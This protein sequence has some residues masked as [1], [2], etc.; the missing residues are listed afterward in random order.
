[1]YDSI[2]FE[3]IPRNMMIELV[4]HA[5]FWLNSF[6][7]QDRISRTLSPRTIITGR[8][9]DYKKHCKLEFGEYCQTH[10]QHDNTMNPR[11]VGIIALC[12]TG[13]EQGTYLFLNLNAGKVIA[14]NQ[15]IVLPMPDKVITHVNQMSNELHWEDEDVLTK[16]DLPNVKYEP[17]DQSECADMEVDTLSVNHDTSDGEVPGI[18]APEIHEELEDMIELD[19]SGNV[20]YDDNELT[21]EE[22]QEIIFEAIVDEDSYKKDPVEFGI[23]QQMDMTYGPRSGV[24]NLRPS[25]LHI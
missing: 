25:I 7:K 18:N 1:V 20:E 16:N 6:P 8:T 23:E 17:M 15:W 14:C 9:I 3:R 11:T 12:P 13:N 10:E 21:S 4:N 24:Y 5:N 22:E 2:P 19:A